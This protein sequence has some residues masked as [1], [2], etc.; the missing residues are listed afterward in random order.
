M[1]KPS[2][3]PAA[4]P[5]DPEQLREMALQ[6][7]GKQASQAAPEALAERQ[8]A[9]SAPHAAASE[10]LPDVEASQDP[11]EPNLPEPAA[12]AQAAGDAQAAAGRSDVKPGPTQAPMTARAIAASIAQNR[13]TE[14]ARVAADPIPAEASPMDVVASGNAAAAANGI[15][16][17]Q[18]PAAEAILSSGRVADGVEDG[19]AEEPQEAGKQGDPGVTTEDHGSKDGHRDKR[20]KKDRKH[21]KKSKKE[22]RSRHS[23]SDD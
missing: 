21:K 20:H 22:K 19:T 11:L 6:V 1:G 4:T 10:A 12:S 7:H 5:T 18:P 17:V 23:D 14:Q 15:E 2:A 3:Q 13:G 8:T 16:A 9:D